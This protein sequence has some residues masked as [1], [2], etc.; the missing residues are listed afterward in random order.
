MMRQNSRELYNVLNRTCAGKLCT[1]IFSMTTFNQLDYMQKYHACF[2]TYFHLWINQW[3]HTTFIFTSMTEHNTK[4]PS[5]VIKLRLQYHT[6][7]H[8]EDT[9][10]RTFT[11]NTAKCPPYTSSFIIFT[12]V[13]YH[14]TLSFVTTFIKTSHSFF[15][16]SEIMKS[17]QPAY[18][19]TTSGWGNCKQSTE[20][21]H[22]H[23]YILARQAVP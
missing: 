16:F 15:T 4:I 5:N 18:T 14:H 11:K 22:S 20:V 23:L 19:I 10:T 8:K 3:M 12:Y 7:L 9:Y 2:K 6:N 13:L 21:N 17:W 1:E